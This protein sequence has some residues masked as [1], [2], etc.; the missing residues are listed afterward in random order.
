MVVALKVR[1][2]LWYATTPSSVLLIYQSSHAGICA[3]SSA[4]W[5]NPTLAWSEI[6]PAV[7]SPLLH[8]FMFLFVS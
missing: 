3:K 5:D 7:T 1:S 4:K 6:I 2:K 8:H